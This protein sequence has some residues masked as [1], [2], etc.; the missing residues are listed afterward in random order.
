MLA[1]T[2]TDLTPDLAVDLEACFAAWSAELDQRGYPPTASPVVTRLL[3]AKASETESLTQREIV[4]DT[5]CSAASVRRCLDRL[6]ADGY[7][8]YSRGPPDL[9]E[10]HYVLVSLT[11]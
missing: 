9:R 7:V 10:H 1:R 2:Q 3:L 5:P 11:P 6:E 8:A 4:D